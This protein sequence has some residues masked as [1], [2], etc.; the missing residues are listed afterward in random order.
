MSSLP[1][2]RR[3]SG[4]SSG[5]ITRVRGRLA[6]ARVSRQP[7]YVSPAKTESNSKYATA[8]ITSLLEMIRAIGRLGPCPMVVREPV[9]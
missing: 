2:R 1:R 8:K 7:T 3:N 5:P 4:S 9:W 6:D